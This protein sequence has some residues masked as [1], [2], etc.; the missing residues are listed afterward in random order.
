VVE[1]IHQGE[2]TLDQKET[3]FLM[4]DQVVKENI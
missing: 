2:G 1:H 3:L 4:M